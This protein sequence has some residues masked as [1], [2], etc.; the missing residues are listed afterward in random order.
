M[1]STTIGM[2]R[3][4]VI[5]V[6]GAVI[7]AGI[8]TAVKL[9]ADAGDKPMQYQQTQY[10]PASLFESSVGD[11]DIQSIDSLF[12]ELSMFISD[13][14][15]HISV[16]TGVRQNPDTGEFLRPRSGDGSGF[17]YTSDGWIVTND[18]VVEGADTVQVV[19]ANG[20]VV[21]GVVYRANDPQLD[22]ALVKVNVEGLPTLELADSNGVRPGQFAIAVGVPFGLENSVTIGHVSAI[23]R[24]GEASDGRGPPRPYSGMIQT[25]ASINPGNSGGP[26]VDINGRVIGINTSIFST[27]GVSSG[28]GFAIPSNIIRAVVDEMI[29]TG[30]FDRGLMGIVPEDMKPFEQAEFKVA[31]GAVIRIVEP[32]DPAD[33]AGLRVN[34]VIILIDSVKITNELDLRVALYAKSP[35]DKINVTY[36]R[37]GK[38]RTTDLQLT[39]PRIV[40]AQQRESDFSYPFGNRQPNTRPDRDRGQMARPTL[41]VSLYPVDDATRAQYDL[42]NTVRGVVVVSVTPGSTADNAGL[43][44]GDVIFS[45]DGKPVRDTE[46]VVEAMSSADWGDRM[47]IGYE[48]VED[49]EVERDTVRVRFRR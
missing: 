34:D 28:I 37:K 7:G 14:V 25:D 21:E 40:V 35:D 22:I 13:A 47:E 30:K 39:S 32:N 10:R 29:E 15:V 23:G 17:V 43:R 18:H 12:T 45:I 4:Y 24:S 26:L 27:S 41:G 44:E 49:G 38:E 1:K 2:I 9:M 16:Q 3:P 46:D 48:R 33:N 6:I 31:A 42:P 36:V 20:R 11:V 19:L 8:I 5:L